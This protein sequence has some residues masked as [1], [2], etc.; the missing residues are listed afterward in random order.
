MKLI[1]PKI[2]VVMPVYNQAAFICRAIESL[3]LQ[4]FQDWELWLINDASTDDVTSAIAAYLADE[5]INYLQN[6]ENMGLG[7]CL[8]IGL[9]K[10]RNEFIAYLPADDVDYRDHLRLLLNKLICDDDAV[11][12][13]SGVRHHYN[14]FSYGYLEG[15]A[16]QLLQVLH[17][18]TSDT[19]IE[20]DELVTDDL[21]RMFWN[22][23][24]K[25]GNFI[26]NGNITCEWV[27]HPHQRHKIIKEP[28]GGINRYKLYYGVKKPLRYHS[29]V[30]NLIDEIEYF[31]KFQ[32]RNKEELPTK[33]SLKI[34]LV[35]ELAYNPERILALEERGHKLYG[36]W[37]TEPYWYNSIGPLFFGNIE[38]I[39]VENWKRKIEEIKPDIIYALLS[40][41]AVPFA[42]E[43]LMN[44]PG[45]PFVW[46]FKEGP[47]I[48]IEKGTW[49]QLIDLYT[50]SD[51]QIYSSPEMR[52][53]FAQFVAEDNRDLLVLDGDLPKKE[54]FTNEVSP[55]LSEVDGEPHTVVPGRPIGLH[56]NTVAEMASHNI[57]LHFYGDFTHGQWKEWIEGT[58]QLAPKYLHIHSNCSQEHWVKEF[59]RYDAGWL[60]FFKSENQGELMR[61][62]WDDLNYPARMATLGAAGL[63]M[64]QRDNAG[65]LVATQSIV[66]KHGL[67]IFF[68][69]IDELSLQLNDKENVK[70]LANNVWQKRMLF[71]FDHHVDKLVCFFQQV[72]RN[73][74]VS[75]STV[76]Q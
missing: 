32:A 26:G 34:L 58:K 72:I 45:I 37:I 51:G 67:G 30:G 11:L 3:R 5:R 61:A 64:L 46:H 53:W 55:K 62:N 76:K 23:L 39:N 4:E 22:K 75:G 74:K 13:F 56:P 42:Q 31:K 48:C 2:S 18:K 69:S 7:V 65:H 40:W 8:N 28:I 41:Q 71:C 1:N 59:S 33:D 47:F 17:R 19:W 14:R 52:D 50:L 29:T 9:A 66:K 38:D 10:A 60:H 27:A 12:A 43:V 16:L 21:A 44:N 20:R 15:Y 36:L 25:A 73:K 68:S 49:K 63:P 57:H 70:H 35:G 54:W 6:E 24:A